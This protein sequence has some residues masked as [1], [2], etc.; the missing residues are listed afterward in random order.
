MLEQSAFV[1]DLSRD[2]APAQIR[3]FLSL[4]YERIVRLWGEKE[5]QRERFMRDYLGLAHAGSKKLAAVVREIRGGFDFGKDA[6]T[7]H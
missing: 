4:G 6:R 5:K 3:D 7:N 1:F 2:D